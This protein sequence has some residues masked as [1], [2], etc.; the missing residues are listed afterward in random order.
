M[1]VNGDFCGGGVKTWQY[2]KEELPK[3]VK[4]CAVPTSN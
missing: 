2:L 1:M 3:P 4:T